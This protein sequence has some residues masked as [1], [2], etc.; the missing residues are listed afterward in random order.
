MQVSQIFL[1]TESKERRQKLSAPIEAAI[2]SVRAAFSNANYQFYDNERIIAFLESCYEKE[3]ISAFFSLQSLAY[4]CDLAR[5][6]LLHE[7]GGWYFD[8][9]LM[10]HTGVEPADR[11]ELIAFRSV[12][13]FAMNSWACDNGIIFAKPRHPALSRAIDNVLANVKSKYYGITPLCPTGPS[14]WGKSIAESSQGAIGG[15]V[16]GDCMELTPLHPRK[17]KS[18]V[19]PDGSIFASCKPAEGG[20]LKLMG[21]ADT[22]NY[23]E[24][25]H[26]RNVY[27]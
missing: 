9:G 4:R 2:N 5:Y 16:F 23:N 17:N 12:Q 22:N 20:D 3:V 1:S 15:L 26:G 27:V 21:A 10:C 8:C 24:L 19:L 18:F 6:C 25:W 14:L 13:R 11:I 7:Y